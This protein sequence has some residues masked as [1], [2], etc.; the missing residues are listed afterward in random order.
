MLTELNP[1][2]LKSLYEALKILEN[3]MNPNTNP[4][5]RGL[6]DLLGIARSAIALAEATPEKPQRGGLMQMHGEVDEHGQ[7]LNCANPPHEGP[8]P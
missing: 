4:D 3:A 6:N 1:A 7:C 2:A 8:C 5:P